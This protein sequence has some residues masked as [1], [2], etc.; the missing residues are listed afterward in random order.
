MKIPTITTYR[1]ILRPFC[2]ADVE[3]LHTILGEKDIL[4]YF[5]N[6]NPPS[7]ERVQK[8]IAHQLDH[9]AE[10]KYGWWAVE[11]ITREGLIGWNG[12]QCLPETGEVEIGYLL[13]R[14]H[15]GKGLATEGARVGLKF[16]FEAFELDRIIALVH[17]ENKASIR[18]VEK[19]GMPFVDRANYFG[20]DIN[21]YAMDRSLFHANLEK[22]C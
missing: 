4:R 5:P 1:L 9:W 12:L 18:V 20:M 3:P 15:W 2:E 16:G 19:L 21:R 22:R 13:C 11:P 7:I 17:P 14:S 10:H 8:F 6:P